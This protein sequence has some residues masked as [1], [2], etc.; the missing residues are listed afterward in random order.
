[1]SCPNK[2]HG[3]DHGC[4][5]EECYEVHDIENE[6]EM[7]NENTL[8]WEVPHKYGCPCDDCMLYYYRELK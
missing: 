1:M 8:D 4:Q 2:E 6:E 3:Y 5:F 7:I